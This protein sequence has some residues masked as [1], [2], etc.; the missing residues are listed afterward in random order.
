M[1]EI[2]VE[3]VIRVESDFEEAKQ[4]H[5]SKKGRQLPVKKLKKKKKDKQKRK[6]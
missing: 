3:T 5:I 4:A 1:S 6:S 2:L